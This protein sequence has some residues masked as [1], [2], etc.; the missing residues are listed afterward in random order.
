MEIISKTTTYECDSIG[1]DVY[2]VHYNEGYIGVSIKNEQPTKNY[3]S[4]TSYKK[5]EA[6]SISYI[7]KFHQFIIRNGDYQGIIDLKYKF[8]IPANKYTFVGSVF[9]NGFAV[10]RLGKDFYDESGPCGLF[11]TKGE[12]VSEIKY[13]TFLNK[14]DKLYGKIGDI[15]YHVDEKGNCINERTL[16]LNAIMNKI[17]PNE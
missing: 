6:E 2:P 4:S 14:D 17:T 9:T 15:T 3:Q 1:V 13:D 7:E 12:I 8:I 5:V 10:V 11:N 16:K